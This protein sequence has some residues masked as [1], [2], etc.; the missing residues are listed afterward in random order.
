[1]KQKIINAYTALI[2]N[3]ISGLMAHNNRVKICF[4]DTARQRKAKSKL[5]DL[6]S[7]THGL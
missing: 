3:I 2:D 6:A 5:L 1:M 4:L 7:R